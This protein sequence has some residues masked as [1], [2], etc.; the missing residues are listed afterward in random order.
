MAF[1]PAAPTSPGGGAREKPAAPRL[2]AAR[3]FGILALPFALSLPWFV[4]QRSFPPERSE[5]YS[6]ILLTQPWSLTMTRLSN[7]LAHLPIELFLRLTRWGI[8]WWLFCALALWR[9]GAWTR[10][11]RRLAALIGAWGAVVIAGF[12][13]DPWL[14]NTA[15]IAV[16]MDRLILQAAPLAVV[17]VALN[18]TAARE[19]ATPIQSES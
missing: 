4:M 13:F 5:F 1:D 6:R 8:L 3:R 2:A 11:E 12:V 9:R 17:L 10:R 18:L 15:H 19:T 16:S 14:E 7:T